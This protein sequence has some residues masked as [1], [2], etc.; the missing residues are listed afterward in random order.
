MK[1]SNFCSY[2]GGVLDCI[3]DLLNGVAVKCDTLLIQR[4]PDD[5]DH[6]TGWATRVQFPASMRII[7]GQVPSIRIGPKRR[8]PISSPSPCKGQANPW[9]HPT[10]MA[11]PF[12]RNRPLTLLS[13]WTMAAAIIRQRLAEYARRG[14]DYNRLRF[15]ASRRSRLVTRFRKLGRV[16][17]RLGFVVNDK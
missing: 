13:S 8:G 6:A 15:A 2:P 12:H 11:E 14:N 17:S 4:Q 3:C 9:Q 5:S 10:K 16:P 7:S 1:L